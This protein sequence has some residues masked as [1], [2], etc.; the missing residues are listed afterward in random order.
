MKQQTDTKPLPRTQSK[1]L[2]VISRIGSLV[3]HPLLMTIVAA[4]ALYKLAPDKFLGMTS[5][6]FTNW[7]REL[8]FFAVIFPF[9]SILLFKLSGLISNARMREARDRILPLIATM[10]FYILAYC[11]F[12]YKYH[13]AFLLQSLL[14]GSSF[15]I[16][17]I[18]IIN[19][20]YKVSVHT[21]A[22]AILPGVCLVLMLHNE[23]NI[24][25]PLLF[26]VLVALFVGI[27]RWLLGAHTI[28][29][30]MLGYIIGILTQ[31]AA[32]FILTAGKF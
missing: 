1:T 20:F 25:L 27:I 6:E 7:M 14:L 24:I 29:Q 4:I 22:A 11:I 21:T 17:I 18:F 15:A 12:V 28:G 9:A 26:A 5:S 30:I 16:V 3:F 8:F 23:V 32:Y 31:Q 2:I 10:I 13:A 19:I